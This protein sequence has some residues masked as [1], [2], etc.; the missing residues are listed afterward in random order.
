MISFSMD[1]SIFSDGLYA[2]MIFFLKCGGL[3]CCSWRGPMRAHGDAERYKFVRTL[4]VVP[5][6]IYVYVTILHNA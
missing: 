1:L 6:L 2:I 5:G 3:W 4:Y